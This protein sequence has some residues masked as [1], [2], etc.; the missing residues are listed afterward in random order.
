MF[1]FNQYLIDTI[2]ISTKAFQEIS[3]VFLCLTFRCGL[4]CNLVFGFIFF[5]LRSREQFLEG[6][7]FCLGAPGQ[8]KASTVLEGSGRRHLE[9]QARLE[10]TL[11]GSLTHSLF[12][13]DH[14][15]VQNSQS[16]NPTPIR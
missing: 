15:A 8:R 1:S 12:N 4:S 7:E 10:E 5:K 3:G 9:T 2:H 13:T 11:G 16:P 6:E 14:H